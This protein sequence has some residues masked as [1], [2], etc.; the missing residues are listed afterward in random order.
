MI[1]AWLEEPCE[2]PFRC[3][4]QDSDCEG[5]DFEEGFF[6]SYNKYLDN[7]SDG[8]ELSYMMDCYI[9]NELKF[10]SI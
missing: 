6:E 3:K 5:C 10:G 8:A 7:R 4:C 1:D 9:M 2:K